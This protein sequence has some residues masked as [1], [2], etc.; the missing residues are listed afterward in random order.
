MVV[1]LIIDFHN[2]KALISI[3]KHKT[4]ENSVNRC[5]MLITEGGDDLEDFPV[6]AEE[7][8]SLESKM[9][10]RLHCKHGKFELFF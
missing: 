10:V 7:A 4:V 2:F 8:D 9:I 1:L 6:D 5:E 3:L